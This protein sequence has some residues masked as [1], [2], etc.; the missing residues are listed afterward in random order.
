MDFR[1]CSTWFF[2][3]R[4]GFVAAGKNDCKARLL[5]VQQNRLEPDAHFSSSNGAGVPSQILHLLEA[6]IGRIRFV[7]ARTPD[8]QGLVA[9]GPSQAT[10]PDSVSADGAW[11]VHRCSRHPV[12]DLL[13]SY[14]SAV[15]VARAGW[16]DRI[17]TP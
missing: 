1:D 15:Q 14:T 16:I 3:I 17:R 9:T 12:I 8:D 10:S 2:A 6:C 4:R 13:V 7:A 11:R 5:V